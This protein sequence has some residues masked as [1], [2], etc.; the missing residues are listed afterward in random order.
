MTQAQRSLHALLAVLSLT[1]AASLAGC[2]SPEPESPSPELTSAPDAPRAPDLGRGAPRIKVEGAYNMYVAEPVRKVCSG[3]A[4]FFEFD[5]SD[6]RETDQPTMQALAECM[7]SGPL[8]G[9]TIQLIGH[10]DPRGTPGY[11]AKLGFERAERVK[12]YLVTHGVA[13]SRVRVESVGEVESSSAP[14]EWAKDR[15]VEIQLVR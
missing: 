5:S 6:T 10:T 14:A 7:I 4:P 8:S 2:R 1:G 9:K 3:S 12:R 15:R 11:N 13:E